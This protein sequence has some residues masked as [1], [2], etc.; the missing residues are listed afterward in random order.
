MLD[1][2]IIFIQN[3]LAQYGLPTLFFLGFLEEILFFIPS[4]FVFVAL[5]FLMID[6]QATALTAFAMA[7]GQISLL[8]SLGVTLGAFCMYGLTYWGGK[9]LIDRYGKYARVSWGDLERIGRWFKRGY[10]DEALLVFFRAIPLFPI[11]IVSIFCG[12]IR[13]PIREFLWTTFVGTVPRVAGL[14]FFGWYVGKEYEQYAPQIA[15]IERYIFIALLI[16]LA[17]FL[18]HFYRS[19]RHLH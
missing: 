10:A 6:P 18:L 2:S 17:I 8:T 12:L 3:F 7:L 1:S 19:H 13:I 5:G 14:A 4:A 9:P 11:T 15:L 16:A